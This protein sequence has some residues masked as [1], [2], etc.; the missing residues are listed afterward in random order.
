M[1]WLVVIILAGVFFFRAFSNRSDGQIDKGMLGL[2]VVVLIVG[3]VLKA[4]LIK[5]LP[6]L[7]H[8]LSL[9]LFGKT[10]YRGPSLVERFAR[11]EFPVFKP[12]LAEYCRQVTWA[13]V[14]FF[15][16]NMVVCAYLAFNAN[17]QFWAFYNGAGI[18]A[19]MAALM[20][21]EYLWRHYRFPELEI[22]SPKAT[23]KSMLR[24]GPQI[25]KEVALQ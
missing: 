18:F 16:F 15:A 6:V 20:I 4:L 23:F 19:E 13:W 22:P 7:I 8:G 3:L 1:G 25:W 12:G 17:D 9:H 10:L 14:L 11:K 21:G 5:F 24:Y 2:A